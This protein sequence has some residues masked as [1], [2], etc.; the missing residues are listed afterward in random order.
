MLVSTTIAKSY[1]CEEVLGVG[2]F[3]KVY[4]VS[5]TDSGEIFAL[6]EIDESLCLASSMSLTGELDIYPQLQ[7]R[8]IVNCTRV[9]RDPE[10]EHVYLEMEY[11][12]GERS[13]NSSCSI[14]ADKSLYLSCRYGR[15]WL[16]LPL[17]LPIFTPRSRQALYRLLCTET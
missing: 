12:N 14:A 9:L 15:Y 4:K 10:I 2:A 1:I 8:Y 6:K 16:K 5:K 13:R 3:G 17:V 7:S 11:C